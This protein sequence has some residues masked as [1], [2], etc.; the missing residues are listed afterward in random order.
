MNR[1]PGA[2]HIVRG[3]PTVQL[4]N[5]KTFTFLCYTAKY[6]LSRKGQSSAVRLSHVSASSMSPSF[7]FQRVFKLL[8]HLLN[9]GQMCVCFGE[10]VQAPVV[11]V[12]L[13]TI[14]T[15]IE[16]SVSLP[17]PVFKHAGQAAFVPERTMMTGVRERRSQHKE[18]QKQR[19][20]PKCEK[21]VHTIRNDPIQ[22]QTDPAGERLCLQL[23]EVLEASFAD[24][25]LPPI[26]WL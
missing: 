21:Y 19:I 10:C 22:N 9:S 17:E 14:F 26:T 13:C 7:S 8:A 1:T 6:F 15:P 4:L 11:A 5:I 20:Q 18:S 3:Q 12:Y 16:S 25:Y 2:T 24:C 23:T